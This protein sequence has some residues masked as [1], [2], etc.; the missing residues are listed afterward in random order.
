MRLINA[1]GVALLASLAGCVGASVT[2]PALTGNP[3]AIAAKLARAC[4]TPTPAMKLNAIADELAALAAR[5]D[6]AAVD[7]LASEWERLDEGAR[8]CRGTK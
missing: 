4:P 8:T 5:G 3:Q 1:T 6:I 2:A 7:V